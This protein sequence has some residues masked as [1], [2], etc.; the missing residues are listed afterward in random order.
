MEQ[1]LWIY[2]TLSRRKEVFKPLQRLGYFGAHFEVHVGDPQR[3]QVGAPE[4]LFQAIELNRLGVVAIDYRIEIISGHL[5]NL[6]R[7]RITF[8]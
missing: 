7:N 3:H 4:K 6:L 2:N 1:A 8:T 5:G